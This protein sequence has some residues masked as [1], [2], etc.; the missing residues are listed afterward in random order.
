MIAI[1][2]YFIPVLELKEGVSKILITSRRT[3]ALSTF[4]VKDFDVNSLFPLPT[5]G[6]V[7]SD[8]EY[9]NRECWYSGASNWGDSWYNLDGNWKCSGR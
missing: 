7:G 3:H 5:G 8:A 6:R 4:D 2:F 1:S 9:V